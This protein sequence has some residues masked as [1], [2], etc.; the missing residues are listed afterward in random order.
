MARQARRILVV[1]D[2]ALLRQ[3][4]LRILGSLGLVAVPAGN[5]AEAI[6]MIEQDVEPYDLAI[7]DL[8]MPERSGWDL[9]AYLRD[10]ERFRALPILAITGVNLSDEE[11]DRIR[12]ANVA[13][14]FKGDFELA[15]FNETV[16]HLLDGETRDTPA[17]PPTV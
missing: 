6:R 5:G 12:Q 1:D 3:F 15:R 10:S 9:I 17:P 11:M 7:L 16:A 14:L 2:D 4:Y 8:H 13:V